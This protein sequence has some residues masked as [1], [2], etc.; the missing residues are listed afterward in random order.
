MNAVAEHGIAGHWLYKAGDDDFEPSQRRARQW[1]ADLLELQRQAGNPLEF[2]EGLKLDLFPDE[3]YAHTP[4]SDFLRTPPRRPPGRFR[5]HGAHRCR[6]PLCG[7][8]SRPQSASSLQLQSG[9]SIEIITSEDAR[10][11]PDWLTFVVTLSRA[12]SAI[13]LALKH[14]QGTEAIALGRKLL[15]RALGNANLSINDLDFRDRC[16]IHRTWCAAAQ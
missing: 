15:N 2:I 1:M 10:P 12:R 6:Q 7:V 8:P 14:Q 3:V 9:Q 5:V 4:G 11:N 13:R 16:R